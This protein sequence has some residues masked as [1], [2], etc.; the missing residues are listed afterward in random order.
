VVYVAAVLARE[1]QGG[2]LPETM[3]ASPGAIVSIVPDNDD[4]VQRALRR[5]AVFGHARLVHGAAR[6]VKCLRLTGIRIL[7]MGASDTFL[8]RC[9][10]FFWNLGLRH[11]K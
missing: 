1:Q 4:I 9:I 3:S 5:L 11:V 7:A 2:R 10:H 6:S 8:D